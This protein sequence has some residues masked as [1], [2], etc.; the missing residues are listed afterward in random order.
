MLDVMVG[1]LIKS[2]L[3]RLKQLT[4]QKPLENHPFRQPC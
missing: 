2:K 1:V 4:Y 3:L